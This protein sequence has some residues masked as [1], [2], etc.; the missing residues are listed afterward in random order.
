M[1]SLCSLAHSSI[2]DALNSL[3]VKM[4]R[5]LL[6]IPNRKHLHVPANVSTNH[7]G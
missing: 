4:T 2:S 7:L 1:V 3:F 6:R 5:R